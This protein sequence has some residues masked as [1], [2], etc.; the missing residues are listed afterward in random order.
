MPVHG[1]DEGNPINF[2]V[3]GYNFCINAITA[4]GWKLDISVF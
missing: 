3:V 4:P 2:I 1:G